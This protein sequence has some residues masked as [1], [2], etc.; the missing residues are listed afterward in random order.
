MLKE[1]GPELASKLY[2]LGTQMLAASHSMQ[3]GKMEKSYSELA[4]DVQAGALDISM[5]C[6]MMVALENQRN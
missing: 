5:M 1:V 4:H 3:Q 2:E 6:G